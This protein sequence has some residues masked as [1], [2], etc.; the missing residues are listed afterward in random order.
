M[1]WL[2]ERPSEPVVDDWPPKPL[3]IYA[4][5]DYEPEEPGED[6]PSQPQED[7]VI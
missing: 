5:I 1:I 4:D 3:P 2:P 7:P 6:D